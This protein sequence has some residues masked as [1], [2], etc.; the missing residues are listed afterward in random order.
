MTI[1]KAPVQGL[2]KSYFNWRGIENAKWI[3]SP[4]D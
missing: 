2:L 1:F 3:G 4:T